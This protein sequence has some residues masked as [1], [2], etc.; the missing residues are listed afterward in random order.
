MP[1]VFLFL[2]GSAIKY[3]GSVQISFKENSKRIPLVKN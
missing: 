1:V 2:N 3:D